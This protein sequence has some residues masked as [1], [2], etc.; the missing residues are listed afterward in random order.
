ME[1]Q[2]L[3]LLGLHVCRRVIEIENDVALV[4]LLHEE[5]LAPVG[6]HLVETG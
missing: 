1:S 3:D 4:N 2:S 6:G 5:V